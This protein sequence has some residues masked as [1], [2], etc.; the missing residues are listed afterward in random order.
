MLFN[1]FSGGELMAFR[2]FCQAPSGY[3]K[4]PDISSGFFTFN[5]CFQYY[6]CQTSCF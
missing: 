3:K 5:L 2:K 6:K 4:N 1:R